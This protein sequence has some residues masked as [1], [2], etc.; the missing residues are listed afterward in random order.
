MKTIAS[1]IAVVLLLSSCTTFDD[2]TTRMT[3]RGDSQSSELLCKV[4]TET[5]D[6][7]GT[8][9]V[10]CTE[11]R[12]RIVTGGQGGTKMYQMVGTVAGLILSGVSIAIQAL[13]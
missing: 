1:L 8:V 13:R 2:G 7:A 3:A 4:R 11:S 9:T 6:R 5:T 12:E 10:T